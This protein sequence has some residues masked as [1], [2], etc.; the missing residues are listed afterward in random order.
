MD[1]LLNPFPARRLKKK[2]RH[3]NIASYNGYIQTYPTPA[4]VS[5]VIEHYIYIYIHPYRINLA[6]YR[7]GI[8]LRNALV[9]AISNKLRTYLITYTLS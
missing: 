9:Y 7:I 8:L 6:T 3:Y 4:M 1:H 2:L 5:I